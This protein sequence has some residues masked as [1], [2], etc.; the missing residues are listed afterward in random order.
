MCRAQPLQHSHT[1][2]KKVPQVA[3]HSW[4][5]GTYL[6]LG[7][8]AMCVCVCPCVLCGVCSWQGA[9]LHMQTYRGS[10]GVRNSNKGH[11]PGNTGHW[12]PVCLSSGIFH[13]P[14]V[15]VDWSCQVI[16]IHAWSE[17][18]YCAIIVLWTGL[19]DFD[20]YLSPHDKCEALQ[21]VCFLYSVSRLVD[22]AAEVL[23][24]SGSLHFILVVIML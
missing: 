24:E 20:Y 7:S 12:T 3:L 6:Q 17:S 15:V 11:S 13:E 5:P 21:Y 4:G 22:L 9:C 19:F 1:E 16:M 2:G 10:T 8:P 14:P 23:C 18:C